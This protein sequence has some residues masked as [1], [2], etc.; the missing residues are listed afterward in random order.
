MA[1]STLFFISVLLL[2]PVIAQVQ[3][4]EEGFV[5]AVISQKGLDFAKDI[6][7]EKAIA[8]LTP[9]NLPR[10]QKTM[11]IPFVGNIQLALSNITIY[12][13]DVST[14][15]VKPGDTGVAIVASGATANLSMNWY[16]SYSTWLIPLVISDKGH[17][18]VEVEGME[19]GLTLGL[20]NQ[21]GKLKL[22][23]ME[24]GCYVKDISI[25][26]DGGAS[27][28]YQGF[29][30]AFEEQIS[31]AVQNTITKKIKEG[32]VELDSL[33]NTLP[34]EI[35]VDEITT[36]N[37]TFVN[38]PLLSN[39][40]IEIE[41][42]GLFMAADE[43]VNPSYY[44]KN[45]K[46]PASCKDPPKML[47]ISLDEAVFNSASDAY[48]NADFMHWIVDK[49]PDQYLL[50]TAGWKY[51]VPQLYKKYPNDDM[52]L[53]ISVSSPPMIRI[54][55]HN[56][57]ATIYSDMTID[58]LDANE[59]I[60]VAC[61]SVV[62]RTS[63]SLEIIGNN[64]AGNVGLNDFSLSLKWSKIGN[65][66]MYLIQS[67]MW[68]LL[69]TVFLPYVNL[70]LKRGFPLPILRGFNLQDANILCTNSRI[71]VCSDVAFSGLYYPK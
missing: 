69:K 17:A 6:L 4:N 47:E 16:Y 15:T 71:I 25:T 49:V 65:F 18:S 61:I 43:V 52:N 8:S 67:V 42:D 58:V 33:L 19:V 59:T 12:R 5:S 20:E 36:L 70:R 55:P 62:V 63:V 27:W 34:K 13:V 56:I 10:I 3:S 68:T 41:I 54:S 14:S 51:I 35:P 21:E 9:L 11:K 50:N 39:S 23:L 1:P 48:F 31:S 30:D 24:C 37:V 29:V 7:I 46:S 26:L 2:V 38:D 32:V 64:L 57:D 66:H 60:P 44:H 40:S 28:L 45:S 22:S 53:N